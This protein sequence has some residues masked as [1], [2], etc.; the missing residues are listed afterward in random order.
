MNEDVRKA[1][2]DVCK[3]A[4]K[5]QNDGEFKYF[6]DM[7]QYIKK[8]LDKDKEREIAGA[9]HVVVGKSKLSISH[10]DLRRYIVWSVL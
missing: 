6:R 10:L 3:D 8:T 5:R 2:V 1:V 9:W 7:A 4:Y